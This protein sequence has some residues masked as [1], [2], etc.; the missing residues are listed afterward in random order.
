MY[1]YKV[2]SNLVPVDE[3]CPTK[4]FN[5]RHEAEAAARQF[6]GTNP[7]QCLAVYG[8]ADSTWRAEVQHPWCVVE[9][10][11]RP[12]VA[13]GVAAAHAAVGERILAETVRNHEPLF[14][15]LVD[16]KPTGLKPDLTH[17]RRTIQYY[18]ARASEYGTDKYRQRANYLRG[19]SGTAA[20]V[21]RLRN[22]LRAMKDHADRVLEAVEVHQAQDPEF[23]DLEGLKRA[24]YC[25]DEDPDVTGTVGPSNLPNLC[26]AAASLNMALEQAVM[27]GLLPRDPGTPWKKAK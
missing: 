21:A 11:G 20:D 14:T 26:G 18:I 16:Q 19:T 1:N 12:A 25:A 4:G 8:M 5:E 23:Q 2:V 22:Y 7:N 10:K 9:D 15:K 3:K 27:A 13:Q 17:V 6:F 24:V